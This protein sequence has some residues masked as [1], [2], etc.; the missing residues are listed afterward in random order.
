VKEMSDKKI[1]KKRIKKDLYQKFKN[2]KNIVCDLT[3]KLLEKE[4]FLFKQINIWNKK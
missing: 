4:I 3:S 1:K 2:S